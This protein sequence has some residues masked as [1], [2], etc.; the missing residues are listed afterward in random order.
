MTSKVVD[1]IVEEVHRQGYDIGN[2]DGLVRIG[3]M[4]DAWCTAIAW[5]HVGPLVLDDAL[6]LGRKIEP[7]TN[8]H[9]VRTAQVTVGAS[10]PPRPE[11]INRLL[12][13]LFESMDN[14]SP[15]EFYKEFELIHPFTDGNGRTGKII[16]NWLNG[17]LLDPIF[18]PN[19]LFGHPSS[20]P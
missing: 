9:G 3:W 20:N 11:K 14:F 10:V 17:T 19:D 12:V 8:Y 2:R 18:P 7:I 1:Y 5:A 6:S 15:I 4:I 16:L 13:H